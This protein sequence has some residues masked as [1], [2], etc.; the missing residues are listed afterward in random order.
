MVTFGMKRW[1]FL[2]K[3]KASSHVV[4]GARGGVCVC[5]SWEGA[6]CTESHSSNPSTFKYPYIKIYVPVSLSYI[7]ESGPGWS[8]SI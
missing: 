1:N 6:T 3:H 4:L 7:K 2:Y 5:Y 8:L